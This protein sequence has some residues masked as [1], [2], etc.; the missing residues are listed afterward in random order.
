MGNRNKEYLKK[1]QPTERP[2]HI[3]FEPKLLKNSNI[4]INYSS[5]SQ[6][7]FNR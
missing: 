4:E 6:I 7:S 2:V 1:A 3:Y 5:V